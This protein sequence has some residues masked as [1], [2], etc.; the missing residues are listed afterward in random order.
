MLG[1]TCISRAENTGRITGTTKITPKF[2]TLKNEQPTMK[3]LVNINPHKDMEDQ[4]RP[5]RSRL[6]CIICMA[7][8]LGKFFIFLQPIDVGC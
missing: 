1:K 7:L 3:F 4:L 8:F 6:N 5:I 2:I